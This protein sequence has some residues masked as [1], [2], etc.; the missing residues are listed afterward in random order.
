VAR[1]V[2]DPPGD[3]VAS[4]CTRV[5]TLD[6]LDRCLGCGRTLGEI[7]EWGSAS[8]SR[9]REILAL[10]PARLKTLGRA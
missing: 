7:V 6:P 3:Q 4:P 9:R 1:P 2:A 5:C 8:N 10:L